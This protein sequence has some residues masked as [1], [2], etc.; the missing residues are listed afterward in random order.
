MFQITGITS[1]PGLKPEFVDSESLNLGGII[2]RLLP[3][4]IIVAGLFFFVKLIVAGFSYLTSAGDS[5]KIQSATKNL[6][7]AGLGLLIVLTAYFLAQIL[8]V[9]LGVKIL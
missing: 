7:N 5:A 6:T 1:P 3:F 2:S 8:E 4:A 9:V